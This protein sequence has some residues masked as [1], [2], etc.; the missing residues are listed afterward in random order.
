LRW[1]PQP[2]GLRDSQLDAQGRS[3]LLAAATPFTI[4]VARYTTAGALDASFGHDGSVQLHLPGHG[5]KA[6]NQPEP[7]VNRKQTPL[8]LTIQRDGGVIVA[9]AMASSNPGGS[10]YIGRGDTFSSA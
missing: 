7:W 4:N 3:S 5:G 10:R 9:F 8:A 6:R 1:I 2:K